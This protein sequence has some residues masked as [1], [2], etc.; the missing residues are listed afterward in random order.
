[1]RSESNEKPLNKARIL[2]FPQR[3]IYNKV[4]Y[5][6]YLSEFEDLIL[7]M[8]S[9]NMLS[10]QPDRWFKY[11]TRIAQRLAGDYAISFN[12]GI[13][14]LKINQ[15]YDLFFAFCQFPRDLLHIESVEGWKDRCKTSICWLSEIYVSLLH[16][17]RYYLE[18]ILSKFDFVILNMSKS[19][20]PVNEIIGR[21]CLFLPLGI[22]AILFCP[23]PNAPE[24]F[25]D[26]YS[27]GRKSEETHRTLLKMFEKREILYVYDTIIGE[28]VIDTNQHRLLFAN[29][30]KRSKYFI[31]NPGKVDAFDETK[32]QSE[33][34]NRY[35]EGAAA[36][37]IMIG[38]H[39]EN[40]EFKNI[41][42]WE[43]AVIHLPYNSNKIQEIIS[44]FNGQPR[45]QAEIRTK[46]VVESLMQH[47]WA[48]RWET[49][50]KIAGL[51]PM[52][53]LLERKK[54]LENLSKLVGKERNSL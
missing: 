54:Q 26:V 31:V 43:D 39:P 5:R 23:Y 8:D 33:I 13:P 19:V 11:G 18:N 25:I 47:D 12:P 28:E 46:N 29:L 15:D 38:D 20:N 40:E 34:G 50:L 53:G 49:I 36:G 52:P 14:K 30:A 35:F 24:R 42:Y 21:K 22:D 51:E 32:G 17:Y 16:R 4:H 44:E 37:S 3:N 10:P 48:Y 27:I 1:M 7:Q 2:I 41:F 9:V 6:C 45:R